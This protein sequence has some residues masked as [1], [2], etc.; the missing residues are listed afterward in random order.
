M[1]KGILKFAVIFLSVFISSC[2]GHGGSM[3]NAGLTDTSLLTGD[4]SNGPAV[5]ANKNTEPFEGMVSLLYSPSYE[6]ALT[7]Q[8]ENGNGIQLKNER[9]FEATDPSQTTV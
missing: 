7:L 8:L 6:G 3:E 4:T 5:N 2:G 1:K 9:L